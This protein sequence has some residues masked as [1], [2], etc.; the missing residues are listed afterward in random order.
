MTQ[1]EVAQKVR[2]TFSSLINELNSTETIPEAMTNGILN[3]LKHVTAS[4][5]ASVLSNVKEGFDIEQIRTDILGLFLDDLCEDI[6]TL[7]KND[8]EE[9]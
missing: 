9:N 4:V 5:M 8:N 7:L 6:N 2:D 3:G 1:E